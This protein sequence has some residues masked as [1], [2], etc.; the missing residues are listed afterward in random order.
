M[1]PIGGQPILWHILKI[2]EHFGIVD[3]VIAAGYMAQAIREWALV[4][5]DQSRILTVS[6]ADGRSE[7]SLVSSPSSW[8]IT[9]ID[10]GTE[11][12]TAGRIRRVM[13]E[14][15]GEAFAMTYG[16]GLADIDISRLVA[17]HESHGRLATVTAVR[18][19]AR[20]GSLDLNGDEVT[21]FG[22]KVAGSEGWINGGFFVLN[23]GVADYLDFPDV[24]D[25]AFEGQPLMQLADDGQLM[26]YRHETFWHPMD[27]LRDKHHLEDLWKS[28]GAPWSL[29]RPAHSRGKQS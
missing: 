17:F 7:S 11:T 27:T 23:A 15:P 9:V 16:D 2:Y 4:L 6:L 12:Q 19:P 20:F 1:V 13:R 3:F 22:E 14:F 5:A 18:P 10:T 28:G 24:D 29:G 25:S 26:A 8:T 21:G